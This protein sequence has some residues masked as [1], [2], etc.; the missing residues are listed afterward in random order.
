MDR[1]ASANTANPNGPGPNQRGLSR[2]WILEEVPNSLRRLGTDF[3]DIL[4]LHKEVVQVASVFGDQISSPIISAVEKNDASYLTI[5][6]AMGV[7]Y[8]FLLQKESEW[9]VLL[10]TRNLIHSWISSL[11]GPGS[12]S[13]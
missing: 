10:M 8:L 13:L 9:N 2:K 3:V 7:I 5:I 12:F 4:Y 1:P 11:Y 6:A